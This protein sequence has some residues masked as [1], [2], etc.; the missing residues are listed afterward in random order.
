MLAK[1]MARMQ[2]G[3]PSSQEILRQEVQ[4]SA[5]QNP[6]C[7]STKGRLNRS[8]GGSWSINQE[9]RAAT[10]NARSL[11]DVAGGAPLG[12]DFAHIPISSWLAA[13][14][15]TSEEWVGCSKQRPLGLL[16]GRLEAVVLAQRKQWNTNGLGGIAYHGHCVEL[17][18]QSDNK[19]QNDCR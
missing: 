1:D 11:K 14:A 10:D 7:N 16:T 13:A 3:G 9:L 19:K 18:A 2:R 15:G 12:G 8:P 17:P 4:E 6:D 5:Y